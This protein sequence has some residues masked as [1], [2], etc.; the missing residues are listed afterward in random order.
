MCLS[1]M[2]VVELNCR[3]GVRGLLALNVTELEVER[4]PLCLSLHIDMD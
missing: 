4:L 3:Q 1:S 2:H